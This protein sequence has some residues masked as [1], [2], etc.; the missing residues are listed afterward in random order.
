[1]SLT[2]GK[3]NFFVHST[4]LYFSL[5][6]QLTD[7][8]RKGTPLEGEGAAQGSSV[9]RC[10]LG[11][12]VS[13]ATCRAETFSLH[14]FTLS[15]SHTHLCLSGHSSVRSHRTGRLTAASGVYYSAGT[16]VTALTRGT[17][18]TPICHAHHSCRVKAGCQWSCGLFPIVQ[19]PWMWTALWV[20]L[21]NSMTPSLRGFWDS[22]GIPSI[23]DWTLPTHWAA[24]FLIL[25]FNDLLLHHIFKK[26]N[27]PRF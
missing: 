24:D 1:M 23:S 27:H 22:W 7:R 12:P 15:P 26:K 18:A 14:R 5:G 13:E 19:S 4:V 8:S 3:K 20:T 17:E 6:V 25:Y 16:I 11:T 9:R 2:E 21:I 10:G